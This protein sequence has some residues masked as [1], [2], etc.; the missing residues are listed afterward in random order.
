MGSRLIRRQSSGNRC[1]T[2]PRKG[3]RMFAASAE[4]GEGPQKAGKPAR[5]PEQIRIGTRGPPIP[6]RW[7]EEGGGGAAVRHKGPASGKGRVLFCWV[8]KRPPPKLRPRRWQT[9]PPSVRRSGLLCRSGSLTWSYR[10]PAPVLAES[11]LCLAAGAPSS[12]AQDVTPFSPGCDLLSDFSPVSSFSP[13][14]GRSLLYLIN[15]QVLALRPSQ[16]LWGREMVPG[17][18]RP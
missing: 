10:G 17:P 16:S 9:P 8:L 18:D 4:M 1:S 7:G 3:S 6:S 13:S 11:P 2:P 5:S 14:A 12:F 15:P